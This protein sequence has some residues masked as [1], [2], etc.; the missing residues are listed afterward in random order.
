MGRRKAPL[1]LIFAVLLLTIG[2]SYIIAHKAESKLRSNAIVFCDLRNDAVRHQ[3][4]V[5]NTFRRFVVSQARQSQVK[6][7]SLGVANKNS[8][9]KYARYYLSYAKK[10]HPTKLVACNSVLNGR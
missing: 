7:K 6:N 4:E 3:N 10:I 5:A 8:N 1:L 9:S 2:S